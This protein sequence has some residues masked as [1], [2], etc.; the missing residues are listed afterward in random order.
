MSEEELTMMGE[1]PLSAQ[2]A[3][4][5]AGKAPKA[6]LVCI[7]DSMLDPSQRGLTIELDE[8]EL[9]IGRDAACTVQIRFAKVSKQHAR[10]QPQNG[11]WI[12]LDLNSTNGVFVNDIR[13]VDRPMP[14]LS[15]SYLRIASV[16]FKFVLDRPEA[17]AA[18]EKNVFSGPKDGDEEE[19][20]MYGNQALG[21]AVD[22]ENMVRQQPPVKIEMPVAAKPAIG[23]TPAPVLAPAGGAAKKSPMTM[24]LVGVAALA[25]IGGGLFAFK[26]GAGPQETVEHAG[27]ALKKVKSRFDVMPTT[28]AKT[29]LAQDNVILDEMTVKLEEALKAHPDSPQLKKLLIQAI[30]F[31]QERELYVKVSD[32]KA[33][34]VEKEV[35][36]LVS[37]L[38][39]LVQGLGKEDEGAV[40]GELLALIQD[41]G[42][43]KSFLQ[44]YPDASPTAKSKP[45]AEEIA[46]YREVRKGFVERK[47]NP[48]INAALS[49]TYPLLNRLASQVANDDLPKMDPWTAQ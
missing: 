12:V 32:G 17:A 28:I 30:L 49:V 40:A 34:A 43:L 39:G 24:I 16:P 48:K 35:E 44:R 4:G 3:E 31:K 29:D 14:L 45:A 7:D 47:K 46:R 41:V 42:W 26:G 13:V 19:G 23:G 37:R 2:V 11:K 18:L 1:V 9:T 33:E 38:G 15:G 27:K 22:V 5:S 10:I 21:R 36:P 6:K 20:T 8:Q 25:L